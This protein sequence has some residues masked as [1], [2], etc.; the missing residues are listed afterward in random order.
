V[1]HYAE[2]FAFIPHAL[3]KSKCNFK[4]IRNSKIS[5]ENSSRKFSSSHAKLLLIFRVVS[6]FVSPLGSAGFFSFDVFCPCQPS[7]RMLYQ[8]FHLTFWGESSITIC[9][10]EQFLLRR[11]NEMLGFT[12][13]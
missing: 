7:I 2:Y 10:V 1:V 8:V 9:T 12:L 13:I 11:V 5:V 3:I 6:A 4:F